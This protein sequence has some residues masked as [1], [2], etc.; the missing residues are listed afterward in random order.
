MKHPIV[1]TIA[2]SDSGG[3]A[4]IQADLKTMNALGVYG[5]SVI[6]ALTA[7]NTCGVQA[8]EYPSHAFLT[9]QLQSLAADFPPVAV[10]LGMLGDAE[11]IQQVAKHL[12]VLNTYVLCDPVMVSTSGQTLLAE[13]AVSSLK[14]HLLPLVDLLTPNLQEAEILTGRAIQ[15]SLDME[16]AARELL[17]L[18]PKSVL[19]KGGH[20]QGAFSQDY[21][22]DGTQ[23]AW[24]TS[25]R[26]DTSNTHGTGCTLSAALVSCVGLGMDIQDALIVAKA[27]VNQ[28]LRLAPTIGSGCGPLAH[29]GWPETHQDLPWLTPNASDGQH[30]TLFPSCGSEPLGFYPIVDR[31][32]WL[33]KLLPLGVSTIQLRIKDL[34]GEALEREISLASSYAQKFNCRLFINDHWQLALKY[35]AYG[36]HLGQEDLA[37]ADLKALQKAGLRLGISTHCYQEVA[38]ALAIRPSYVAVGPIFATT[39]KV[40]RFAPQGLEALQRWRHSLPYPLVA[41][42]GIFLDSAPEILAAGADGIAVVRD[43]RQARHLPSQ[44]AKWL[45]LF[46]RESTELN[47]LTV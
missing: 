31:F 3:G 22:T 29:L 36:M 18:G 17:T 34:S 4:G 1:W 25:P 30:R 5:C 16:I 43:I 35:K 21:W 10:K 40:M 39:T 13:A 11:A 46:K 38:R 28:G 20:F 24:L 7:Q 9:A 19:L 33:E 27:Y 44:V 15:T 2:G 23:D 6:T 12:S 8:I 42:G 45:K 32:E 26:L 14:A 41:I 47:A 37:T